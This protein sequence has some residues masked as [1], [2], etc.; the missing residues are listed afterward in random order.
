M[1]SLLVPDKTP[2]HNVI[3]TS[4]CRHSMACAPLKNVT[5]AGL[6]FIVVSSKAKVSGPRLQ[7][8]TEL[9]PP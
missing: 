7:D 3:Q 1:L 6:P 9:G 8:C 5:S 4:T 2:V